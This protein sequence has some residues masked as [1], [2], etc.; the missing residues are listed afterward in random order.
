VEYVYNNDY[1]PNAAPLVDSRALLISTTPPYGTYNTPWLYIHEF[2]VDDSAGGN[3][4]GI[5]EP[6]ETI[7]II[8]D[9]KN[10][11]DTTAYNVVGTLRTT[12]TDVTLL[13]SLAAYGDI[14]AGAVVQGSADPYS[15]HVSAT[16]AD[17]TLAFVLHFTDGNGYEKD[18]YF[19]LHV[20]GVTGEEENTNIISQHTP[21][22]SISPNPFSQRTI[23]AYCIPSNSHNTT[24]KMY[25]ISGRLVMDFSKDLAVSGHVETLPWNGTDR[26]GRHLASGV[27]FLHLQTGSDQYMKKTILVK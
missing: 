22:I 1:D 3:N 4:N 6:D 11:G 15:I 21:G 9:T 10:G 19:T 26:V 8:I 5:I 25:D 13:D 14:A 12:D 24:L 7:D 16:P 27:Y 17:S 23:I 20:Y 18:D 2:T